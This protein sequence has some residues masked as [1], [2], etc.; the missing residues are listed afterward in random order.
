MKPEIKIEEGI[1]VPKRCAQGWAGKTALEMR[2]GDSVLVDTGNRRRS[3]QM[4]IVRNYGR[5][6]A[7]TR[8]LNGTGWRVWRVK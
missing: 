8:K 7:T 6:S 1:P 3:L 4:Q 5:K 2:P